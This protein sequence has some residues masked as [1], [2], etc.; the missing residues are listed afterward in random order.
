[1]VPE[2]FTDLTKF[3]MTAFKLCVVGCLGGITSRDGLCT[4]G[5]CALFT[6]VVTIVF[7][8]AV[9]VA[10]FGMGRRSAM[11]VSTRGADLGRTF[12]MVMGG[13]RLLTFVK[14]LLAFGLYARVTGDFTMCCFGY[15]YRSRCL[16]SVFKF[17]VVTRVT[18]LLYFPGVTT[19]V[20]HRGMCTFTY[21]LPVTKFMLL[22]TTKCMT[23]RDG[24]LIIMYYTLLFFKSN[25][26]LKMAAYYVTSIVSCK[27]MGFN[28]QGRDMAYSTRAFLVGTTATTTNKLAKVNLRVMKCGTG[29]MARDTTAM[30]N[31]HILVLIVPVVLTFTDF[32][33]CGGCCALGN[34]GVRRVAE[35]MGRVRT[36][37][38]ATWRSAVRLWGK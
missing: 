37:G 12:R 38:R 18:K 30:V 17:T 19:G 23:P 26:S 21:K 29:T 33:V 24:I 34:R 8:I 10:M 5:K 2:F 14:L 9:N 32:N 22:N 6:V 27:R 1:M 16:C 7:V 35:G 36:G 3:S 25:L 4:R 15:M 20:G 13:S 31:V 28:M 11:N